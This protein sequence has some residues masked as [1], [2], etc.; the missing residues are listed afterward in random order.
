MFLFC[1]FYLDSSACSG[2]LGKKSGKTI[3][4]GYCFDS[5]KKNISYAKELSDHQFEC[6]FIVSKYEIFYL[7]QCVD[8][9]VNM[10]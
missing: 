4:I 9:N 1:V 8:C 6:S 5:I 3:R 10:L 2:Y 7:L